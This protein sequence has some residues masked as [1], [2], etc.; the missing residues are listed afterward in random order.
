MKLSGGGILMKLFALSVFAVITCGN[1]FA[2]AMGTV[3]EGL[4]QAASYAIKTGAAAFST[5][6]GNLQLRELRVK[7]AEL[8]SLWSPSPL[9]ARQLYRQVR[10]QFPTISETEKLDE[11]VQIAE[12]LLTAVLTV[13]SSADLDQP[14]LTSMNAGPVKIEPFLYHFDIDEIKV[15][16]YLPWPITLEQKDEFGLRAIYHAIAEDALPR[17]LDVLPSV[18]KQVLLVGVGDGGLT[19]LYHAVHLLRISPYSMNENQLKV[20]T[21]DTPLAFT[22]SFKIN[23]NFDLFHSFWHVQVRAEAKDEEW[24]HL[25]LQLRP[26]PGSISHA[27][28]LKVELNQAACRIQKEQV[29]KALPRTIPRP[30][31]TLQSHSSNTNKK[32][33][34]GL[35]KQIIADQLH[36][37]KLSVDSFKRGQDGLVVRSKNR[38]L[39]AC[40]EALE[41][42]LNQAMRHAVMAS[43]DW[44][45]AA[46]GKNDDNWYK[47]GVF[48][49]SLKQASLD[50]IECQFKGASVA[51]FRLLQESYQVNA[52]EKQEEGES[53]EADVPFMEIEDYEANQVSPKLQFP[54]YSFLEQKL[55]SPL[56]QQRYSKVLQCVSDLVE[57]TPPSL[58]QL[59]SPFPPEVSSGYRDWKG[60]RVPFTF[61]K[62]NISQKLSKL[63][64]ENFPLFMIL[65]GD[66]AMVRPP[67][68]CTEAESVGLY[69][70]VENVQHAEKYYE[71]LYHQMLNHFPVSR[72]KHL[73]NY[74]VQANGGLTPVHPLVFDVA[75]FQGDEAR[76]KRY[77]HALKHLEGMIARRA[78]QH[79]DCGDPATRWISPELCPRLCQLTPSSNFCARVAFASGEP[80][81]L[82]FAVRRGGWPRSGY[83]AVDSRI[84][85]TVADFQS[86]ANG[87]LS[88]SGGT[89]DTILMTFEVD[90]RVHYVAVFISI[91]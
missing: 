76:L 4:L 55:P 22:P 16:Y 33:E 7:D 73:S 11:I 3:T 88:L 21:L 63:A 50:L 15:I 90:G 85:Q 56:H 43:A 46:Y 8:S 42:M 25:G 87:P 23:F 69:K 48:T 36:L 51:L 91:H 32:D 18:D 81:G 34:Y 17:L 27:V 60:Q 57:Q 74:P 49:C 84:D 20:L 71:L 62:G 39:F 1:L 14:L 54:Q 70:K 9:D 38:H 58:N 80:H 40:V 10:T 66:P 82:K 29:L 64:M 24:R 53:E 19:G 35:M 83:T 72:S 68:S 31:Y 67:P 5:A 52:N 77:Q 2:S 65:V 89:H 45:Q 6:L 61:Y 78:F 79:V 12:R 47:G 13:V 41:T 37:T 86:W 30:H 44:W 26:L 59:L 28:E 75:Y